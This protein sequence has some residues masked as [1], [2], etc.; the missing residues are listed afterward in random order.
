[1][2]TITVVALAVFGVVLSL[3]G[4]VAVAANVVSMRKGSTVDT[5][6]TGGAATEIFRHWQETADWVA[7]AE[8]GPALVDNIDVN[9]WP[10]QRRSAVNLIGL[11]YA[12]LGRYLEAGVWF[13][14]LIEQHPDN[15]AARAWLA[16][17]LWLQG[18][19]AEADKVAAACLAAEETLAD[20]AAFLHVLR[21]GGAVARGRS[22]DASAFLAAAALAGPSPR[23]VWLAQ[24]VR[25]EL[26]LNAGDLAGAEQILAD[27]L[28]A[29]P[30]GIAEPVLLSVAGLLVEVAMRA[31]A[32]SH[33]LEL[34]ARAE[35]PAEVLAS[36]HPELKLVEAGEAMIAEEFAWAEELAGE[37]AA[38]AMAQGRKPIVARALRMRGRALVGLGMLDDARSCFGDALTVFRAVDMAPE[39]GVTVEELRQISL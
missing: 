20:D 27:N 29:Q 5:S 35:S 36:N 18:E 28:A 24:V 26:L 6:T 10:D 13:G 16:R 2:P 38:L 21:A 34:W 12:N 7:L 30:E 23:V 33:G 15:W 37:A 19:F 25:A 9:V 4:V 22:D 39:V 3:I 14:V 17:M 11:A 8:Q 32:E 31:P 1:V